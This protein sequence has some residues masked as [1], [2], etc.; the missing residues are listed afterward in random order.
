MIAVTNIFGKNQTTIPKEVRE[1]LGLE[2]N[3]IIEWDVNEKNEAIL[4]FKRK[5]TKEECESF[6][7]KLDEANKRMD[8]GDKVVLDVEAMLEEEE[9]RI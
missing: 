9:E 2:K 5:Y 3:M 6:F 7:A 1:R 8:K 4:K